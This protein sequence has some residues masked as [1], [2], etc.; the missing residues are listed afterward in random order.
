M[1]RI[2]EQIAQADEY[3]LNVLLNALLDR[4]QY[5]R[6]D[7]DVNVVCIEKTSDLNAQMDRM[8]DLLENMKASEKR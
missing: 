4:Y 2:L 1:E 6:P 3:Q 8:I 7:M 5:V